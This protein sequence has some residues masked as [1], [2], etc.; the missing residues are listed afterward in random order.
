M[1]TKDRLVEHYKN[2]QIEWDIAGKL[3]H[4]INF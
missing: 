2:G 3:I 4:E 1:D